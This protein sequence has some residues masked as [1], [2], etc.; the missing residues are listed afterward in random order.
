MTSLV[1]KTLISSGNLTSSAAR[2][3]SAS[4]VAKKTNPEFATRNQLSAS[5]LAMCSPT[6][7]HSLL[8]TSDR[9]LVPEERRTVKKSFRPEARRLRTL[10]RWLHCGSEG[11]Y[12]ADDVGGIR[13]STNRALV[14]RALASR[15]V[16]FDF[17][18]SDEV[19]VHPP[20]LPRDPG[21]QSIL[22]EDER[23]ICKFVTRRFLSSRSI[24]ARGDETKFKLKV[25]SAAQNSLVLVI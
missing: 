19:Y 5:I 7:I 24:D 6:T 12:I 23:S 13:K 2:L 22:D 16:V 11:E 20:I 9:E 8:G 15:N 21:P 4:Q 17:D 1:A 3:P 25:M 10:T 18:D 14:V